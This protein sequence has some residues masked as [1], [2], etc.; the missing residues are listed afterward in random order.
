MPWKHNA[1]QWLL[2]ITALVFVA[3][4]SRCGTCCGEP[5]D[6]NQTVWQFDAGPRDSAVERSAIGLDSQA[7]YAPDRGFG[8]THPP[9]QTFSRPDLASSRTAMTIDGVAGSRLGIRVDVAPGTWRLALWIEVERSGANRP[10]VIV[11]GEKRELGWQ[12]FLQEKEPRDSPEETYRVYQGTAVAAAE[13]VSI[14]LVGAGDEVRLLGLTVIRQ[15]EATSPQHRELQTQLAAAGSLHS[16]APLDV[17]LKQAE[18]LRRQD[19]MDAYAALWRLRLEILATAERLYAMRGWEWADEQT[20]MGMFDRLNQAVMLLDGLLG[21]DLAQADLL[22]DRAL[23]LRGRLLYWLEKEGEIAV[24]RND[25]KKLARKYPDDD[26]LAMYL[27]EKIVLPDA[28]DGLQSTPTAPAW[29]T[30]QREALCRMRQ[31]SHWWVN[32]RQGENG[33]FGGKFGDDVELL[34]WW[35]PLVLS[36]D[37]TAR[38]G[39]QRLADGVWQSRHIDAGYAS[40]IRD[41]EHAAEFV[42]DTAPMMVAL[43]DDPRYEQRLALSVPHFA[44]LWTGVTP[45]GHRFFRS[46]W[47]SSSAIETEPPKDRDVEYTA[48]AARSLRYLA[49]RRPNPEVVRLLHEWSQGWASAAMRTD[50]GKPRGIVPPSVRFADEAINGDEPT[51]HRSNMLWDYYDWE[52]GVGSM[53]LDQLLFTYTLTHDEKLLEP[54]MAALDLIQAEETGLEQTAPDVLEEGSRSWAADKLIR[55]RWFWSVVQQW[56]LLSGDRRWDHLIMRHG[57][58]YA[59]YRISGDERH[60]SE[61]LE[62]ILSSLRYNTPLL[63]SEALHT[64]RVYVPGWEHLKAMLTGDGMLENA[65]PYFAVTWENTDEDFTALVRDSSRELLEVQ[66]FSHSPAPRDVVVRLWQLAPGKYQ[67]RCEAPG[68]EAKVQAVEIESRGQRIQINLPSQRRLKISV[69]SITPARSR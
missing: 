63:T 2:P 50:K 15:V 4:C 35:A 64:D 54:L 5:F 18:K 65:S 68:L 41:V 33:E 67:M 46:A 3:N 30:A 38:Q 28:C 24:S 49:W 7:L 25:L 66:V 13:G 57:T 58:A 42:A 29:S 27:G 31:V 32:Q 36:G 19:P 6:P 44:H 40:R 61:G 9:R 43:S 59:R 22:T 47:F 69:R 10:L 37:E 21:A 11:Q 51:W 8:W 20:G 39:W 12:A 48:R 55:S 16:T 1:Q 26:L 14:E 52:E 62:F 53:V 23:F 45:R 56:R 17:V 60:L 34:R